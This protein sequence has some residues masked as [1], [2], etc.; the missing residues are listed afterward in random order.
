MRQT[1]EMGHTTRT[2][3]GESCTTSGADG[4][5]LST[6]ETASNEPHA[7]SVPASSL[8]PRLAALEQQARAFMDAA[9]RI[10]RI[11]EQFEALTSRLARLE[12][13][14]EHQSANDGAARDGSQLA[15]RVRQLDER[16]QN[17]ST[18]LAEQNWSRR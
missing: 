8:E 9:G 2:Q 12:D 15:E 18:L 7:G 4:S 14:S 10:G 3:D 5:L 6:S 16:L 13:R 17:L 11:T 1:A